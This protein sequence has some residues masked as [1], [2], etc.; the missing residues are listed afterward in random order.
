MDRRGRQGSAGA[1]GRSVV[2]AGEYQPAAVHAL[3]HAMNQALGNVGTTV[4]LRRARR[5]VAGRPARVARRARDGD[6]RRTG[7]AAGHPRRQSGLHRAGRPASSPSG[8]PR[9]RSSS[10]TASTSTRP[11]RS[12]TGTCPTRTP[13]RAGAT[14]RSFDGTVTLMQPLIAPLYEGRSAHEVLGG[15]HRRSPIAAT[16]GHRQ[17]LLDARVSRGAGGWT[18]STPRGERSRTPTRSGA[19]AARRIHRRHGARSTAVR[20][21]RSLTAGRRRRRRGTRG[22]GS[23]H[24]AAGTPLR[25]APGGAAPPAARAA[26]AAAPARR[27][28]RRPRDHLPS[29]SRRSGTAASPTTAGCRNCPKPLT[30]VTWD[31]AAWISPQLAERA[32]P[33]RRRRHRADAIAAAPRGCRSSS[34]PASARSRSR[35]SSATAGR[36]AGRVGNAVGEARAVQRLPAAHL[37]RAV[38]RQRPRDRPRPASAICW[39]RPRN[40]TRWRAARRCGS[41]RSSEYTREAGGHRTSMGAHAAA[42]R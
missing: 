31:T 10:T 24:A 11:P 13:S 38:V 8:W 27:R 23:G 1:R 40:I 12:A 6:G 34:C 7:R 33:A 35:C 30:K 25:T 4:T 20:R 2:V 22:T 15:V 14:P 21:R 28:R 5:G 3:A 39:R 29:R 32:R 9:S 18:F 26:P 42:A 19:R 37:G 16:L 36:M 41:R 17:G